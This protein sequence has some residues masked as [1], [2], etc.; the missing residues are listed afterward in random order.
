LFELASSIEFPV[1]CQEDVME[2]IDL[3]AA[4]GKLDRLHDRFAPRFGRQETRRH[5]LN[6]V[7][8]LLLAEGRK[9]VERLTLQLVPRA[10]NDA[11]ERQADVLAMQRFLTLSPWEATDVQAEIQAVFA[12]EFVPA[13]SQWPLGTVGVLDESSFLKQGRESVG[14]A[15]QWCGRLGQVANCQTGVFLVGVTPAGTVLLE[16]QLFLP[17]EW[18]ADVERREKTR[19]PAD[20][21]FQT[22][23]QIARQLLERALASGTVKFDWIVADENY[24]RSGEWLDGLEASGQRYVVEV[25]V[26]TSFA[27]SPPKQRTPDETV[28]Q[29]REIATHL[30]ASAWQALALREGAKGPLA[31]E[32]A[33]VRVFAVR[34][35]RIA[36]PCWLLLRRGL[37][38]DAKIQYYVSNAGEE[39]PL[40]TL[41]LLTG[42][43]H[44]VEEFFE[45]A[46]GHLGMA[47]YEA[48]SW[49]SWHHHMSLVALAHLYVTQVKQE[50]GHDIPELT[51]DMAVRIVRT[52]LARPELTPGESL[53]IIEYH[54]RRNQIAHKAHRK[55]WLRNNK[56]RKLK[57]LL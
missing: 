9:N 4:A 10:T 38:V 37:E 45:D 14:V 35:R 15:R 21:T 24:G 32:F 12:E 41:A 50:V 28:H 26:S 33:R 39:V 17:E 42:T 52:A 25:P 57:P 5:S 2:R 54:L 55:K 3:R 8:G 56:H 51:L 11:L 29:A 31:F 49:T 30:P 16:H 48:R 19:V 1:L 46:K 34:H 44:K 6:Y 47:D 36:G 18:A 40:E 43:R 20:V 23:P 22:K 7:R 53:Q 27:I 13:A